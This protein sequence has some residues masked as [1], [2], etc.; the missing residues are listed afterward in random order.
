[1]SILKPAGTFSLSSGN[2]SAAVGMGGGG[3]GA[4]FLA[5]SVSGRPMSGE[6]GGNGAGVSAA[7]G[8]GLAGG[9]CWAFAVEPGAVAKSRANIAALAEPTEQISCMGHLP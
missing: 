7:A 8:A 9:D 3:I 6:P 2:L 4:S 5:A 1:M